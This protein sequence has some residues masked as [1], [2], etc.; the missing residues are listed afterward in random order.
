MTLDSIADPRWHRRARSA[1]FLAAAAV[2]LA[3]AAAA[4]AQ[5]PPSD[6][7]IRSA[8][9]AP[10]AAA[11]GITAP[12]GDEAPD[13]NA[14]ATSDDGAG[15]ADQAAGDETAAVYS[16]AT[17][18]TA[19][20]VAEELLDVPATVRVV[21]GAEAT[22]RQAESIVELLATVAGAQTSSYGVRGQLGSTFVRGAD[23]NQ[24]LVLWNGIPLND[25]FSDEFNFA[26]LASDSLQRVEV[27]P[28]PFSAL[29]G[30]SAM[31]GVVHVITTSERGGRVALEAG[32]RDHRR[33]TLAVG[34]ER[35]ALHGDLAGHRRSGRG[36]TGNDEYDGSELSGRLRWTPRPRSEASLLLRWNDSQTGIPFVGFTPSP[37][38]RIAWRESEGALPWS[39]AAAG[40]E[41][42]GA[43]S[44]VR[45]ENDFR[46]P[47]DPFGFTRGDTD[48]R[49]DRARALATRRFAGGW[50][51]GGGEWERVRVDDSGTFGTN[52]EDARVR[53]A[54]A[55]GELHWERGRWAADLGLRRDDS[56]TFGGATS[57]RLG[58]VVA[59]TP[60]L[61]LR[62]SYGEAFRAP[63]LVELYYP[64][65]GNPDLRPERGRTAEL[66]VTWQRGPWS[67]DL[68][69]FDSRQRD[70]ISFDFAAGR[71][72]NVGRAKS[73]G[74]DGELRFRRPAF[75]LRLGGMKLDAEDAASGQR[76]RNRPEETAHLVAIAR[77]GS[78]RPGSARTRAA[79]LAA[80]VSWVGERVNAYPEFPYTD[81][82]NPGYGTL[83]LAASYEVRPWLTPYARLENALDRDYEPVLGFP[84]ARRALVAGVRLE[85]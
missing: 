62:A 55:F 71:N 47:D 17:E 43:L 56:S 60:Q 75:E 1:P 14:A 48:S 19:T 5:A 84:A 22:A 51:A 36:G 15:G 67:V 16:E 52:L 28:G 81:T 65:S 42:A 10:A 12:H 31:G 39:H 41:L 61:R 2:L 38:R 29:Y 27:V 40:W 49:A 32:Q 25:P 66:A 64:F 77:P 82:V 46:D 44:Q 8:A 78:A 20:A 35:G 33:A 3:A 59:I 73:R 9:A 80:T 6:H 53:T 21:D 13:P 57:P 70:L 34:G 63:A 50:A 4:R 26:F 79:V 23:S 69:A 68:A 76:L 83:D 37:R 74:W 11:E 7:P 24:T 72:V 85:W 58:A 18:V 45:Y 30:S 54:A